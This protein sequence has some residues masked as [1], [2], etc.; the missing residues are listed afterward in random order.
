M[1]SLLKTRLTSR[2]AA[3]VLAVALVAALPLAAVAQSAKLTL[4]HVNDVYQISPQRGVGGLAELMTLLKQER[5][6]ADNHLTTL[7]GDLLSPSVM[8]G[9]TKGAQMVALMNAIGLD[10]AG[11]GNH[12]FD[13]G[14][15]VL[16]ARMAESEFTWLATNTLGSDGAPFGGA[17]ASVMRQVGDFKV[18]IFSLLTA[19][20]SHLSSPGPGVI[21]QSPEE[22]AKKTV[23]ALRGQGAEIVIALTH[24]DIAQDRALARAGGIDIILG[25]HD[26]D[27]IM[28]FESGTLILKAGTDARYLAVADVVLNKRESRGRI[29]VSIRP[30]WKLL[31]TAGVT[32][33]PQVAALVK[34]YEDEFDKEL[35]V[36]VGT[37]SV[38]LDSRRS[39]VRSQES[40][41]GNLIADA[42]RDGVGADIGLTNGGG[43]RGDRTYAAGTKLTRKDILA[44]LPFGNMTLLI[45]LKGADLVAALENG[46]SRIADGAGRFPQVSGLSF[47]FD[48][49]QAAGQ[50][51]SDVKVGGQ[52]VDPARV[53]RV[54][55]NDFIYGGGDGYSAL[56]KG[57]S[58]IDPSGAKL[59]ATMVIDYVT[60]R[61][62]VAPK[63]EGRITG[64]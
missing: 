4:L 51:V 13:F 56:S 50:R 34:T 48:S 36:A 29:R 24:L 11:L 46:V 64:K 61:G 20:T 10:F 54:A 63:V 42:I 35:G 62:T 26:H 59:M 37:T 41:M 38:E 17:Q 28:F 22:V 14:D 1:L 18:G 40:T 45:E 15:D 16:K 43:I 31:S 2:I 53:Y 30:E 55:T 7:G 6:R 27:P 21:I 47:A 5:A 19:E 60:Q 23:A 52:P 49:G 25:G 12:E 39:T 9:L 8:S 32:P 33:D 3:A 44:E 57:R 58:I